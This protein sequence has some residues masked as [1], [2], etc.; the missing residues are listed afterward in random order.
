MTKDY[1]VSIF[2]DG[3]CSVP[4]RCGGAAAY[5]K[6]GEHVRSI[7]TN[8][9]NTTNNRMEL[10]ALILGLGLLKKKCHVTVYSDS[11]YLTEAFNK[12]W[13]NGWINKRWEGVKNA[14]LWRQLLE[15]LDDKT[16]DFEFVWIKGHSGVYY[17]EEADHLAGVERDTALSEWVP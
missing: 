15:A 16:T 3:A 11:K 10:T 2:P 6:Y 5:V 14:D 4:K 1:R 17:N 7:S 9:Q 13:I 8:A 12:K